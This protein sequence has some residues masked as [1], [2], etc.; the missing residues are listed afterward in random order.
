MAQREETP[1]STAKPTQ[2]TEGVTVRHRQRCAS[3]EGGSFNCRPAYLA[4]VWSVRDGRRIWKT[5]P[6][7]V[8]AKAW[9]AD[10]QGAVRRGA[11]RAPT[12][13]SL[14]EPAEAWLAGARVGSTR[15][16]DRYKPSALAG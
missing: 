7:L 12:Q 15:S 2:R 14:R 5:F 16:G 11:M 10:A 1:M 4:A 9:R 8:A 13:A 6:T 3:R